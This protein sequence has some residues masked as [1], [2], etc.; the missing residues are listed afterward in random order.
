MYAIEME[1]NP[2]TNISVHADVMRRLRSLKSA[3]QTWDNF[4]TEMA[5]D[6]TPPSWYEELERRRSAGEDEAGPFMIARSRK[7]A[8]RTPRL[9]TRRG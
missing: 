7:L 6:Y 4:L 3:D 2:L 9:N 5:D 1:S 8:A